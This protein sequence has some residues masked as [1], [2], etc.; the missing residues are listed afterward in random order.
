MAGGR[1]NG[2]MSAPSKRRDPL[3]R[4]ADALVEDILAT[5]G[6][7]LLAETAE[8]HGDARALSAESEK[9]IK[10]LIAEF[11]ARE[12]VAGSGEKAWGNGALGSSAA[13]LSGRWPFRPERRVDASGASL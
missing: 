8:D 11:E 4:L 6:T 10:A 2:L 1:R 3:G 9:A 7:E 13:R 12:G 5:P